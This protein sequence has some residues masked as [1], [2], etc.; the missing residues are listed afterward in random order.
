M[1]CYNDHILNEKKNPVNLLKKNNVFF[2]YFDKKCQEAMLKISMEMQKSLLT[3]H[4]TAK[5]FCH[6]MDEHLKLIILNKYLDLS[7][8]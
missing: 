1:Q 2:N 3:N 7:K 6:A 5:Y 8:S 4:L